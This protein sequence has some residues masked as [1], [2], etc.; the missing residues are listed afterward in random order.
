MKL[1]LKDFV[2]LDAHVRPGFLADPGAKAKMHLSELVRVV[3]ATTE[4]TLDA[5]QAEEGMLPAAGEAWPENAQIAASLAS[6]Q[7][8]IREAVAMSRRA[9]MLS[10]C[11]LTQ[12]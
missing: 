8:Q 6:T 3:G 9:S 1:L 10:V 12:E 7:R 4:R 5:L 11:E 2:E